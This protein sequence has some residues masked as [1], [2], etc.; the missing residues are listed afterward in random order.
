MDLIQRYRD[1]M[2]P[3]IENE[4][5]LK[6]ALLPSDA[7]ALSFWERWIATVDIET[8]DE[9]SQRLLPLLYFRLKALGVSHPLMERFKG[10]YRRNWYKNKVAFHHV[11][12]LLEAFVSEGIDALVL[13][14]AALC[15][16]YYP[17]PG[18]RP[19]SDFDVLVPLAKMSEAVR[20]L[21][22]LE[23]EPIG[24]N[25]EQFDEPY[26]YIRHGHGFIHQKS[27]QEVDLHWHLMHE[28]CSKRI[29]ERL[30]QRKQPLQIGGVTVHTL[31]ATDHLLHTCVHGMKWNAFAPIRW[32]ADAVK[33]LEAEEID[34][35][36]MVSDAV[37]RKVVLPLAAALELLGEE[38]AVA[39]P[40]D[41]I[42]TL[43]A[44]PLDK[45]ERLGAVVNLH[46]YDER[47]KFRR[48]LAW[49]RYECLRYSQARFNSSFACYFRPWSIIIF[50]KYHWEL[51]SATDVLVA[52]VVRSFKK[53]LLIFGMA[54]PK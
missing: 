22:Q 30:W 35:D 43:V 13:K 5:L 16:L 20:I 18:L 44:Y 21:K 54:G 9:A 3:A 4:L 34:W 40:A 12:P 52:I 17:E 48:P 1:G 47:S 29:D 26:S 49:F 8:L 45:V 15:L 10:V 11:S 19:M 24:G 38:Y 28:N 41:V 27:R 23:Y 2:R 50:L 25:W 33:I 7:E 53:G 51:Q 46:Q 31:D 36:R 14:G 42:E 6:A 39:V 37:A 32:I